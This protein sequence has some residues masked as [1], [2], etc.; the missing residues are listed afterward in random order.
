MLYGTNINIISIFKKKFTKGLEY[1][2]NEINLHFIFQWRLTK[3]N[4][5]LKVRYTDFVDECF[6]Q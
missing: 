4:I 2:F 3:W 5:E 6:T 1:I